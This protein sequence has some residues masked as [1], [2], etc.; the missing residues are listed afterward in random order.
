MA[1]SS[2]PTSEPLRPSSD[3]LAAWL[4]VLVEGGVTY[5]YDM[6]RELA[7]RHLDVDYPSVYRMLR[8]LQRDGQLQSRWGKTVAGPRRRLYQ[9]T[10]AGMHSLAGIVD[11]LAA[12]SQT[13]DALFAA[14]A[15]TAGQLD[16]DAAIVPAEPSA[17]AAPPAGSDLLALDS[18]ALSVQDPGAMAVFLCDHAGMQELDRTADAVLVGADPSASKLC[19]IAAEE[20]TEPAALARLMLSVSDLEGALTALPAEIEVQMRGARTATFEGPEGL[21]L[22]F[23]LTG[24]GGIDYDLAHIVLRVA[25]PEETAT[26]LTALGFVPSAEALHVGDTR[27]VLEELPAWSDRPLLRHIAVR[28]GAIRALAAQALSLG[29]EVGERLPDDTV[30]VVLPGPERISFVFA[31][32][33]P[34]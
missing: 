11:R 12:I 23:T 20:P 9:I 18:V 22:G 26:A 27:I 15:Q 6:R 5:G 34:G 7:A 24:L 2:S 25:D 14:Y 32:P 17:P 1:P 16:E 28:V 29:L 3:L 8:A 33:A 4:L 21:G 13:H 19:L 10:P 31:P 30:T